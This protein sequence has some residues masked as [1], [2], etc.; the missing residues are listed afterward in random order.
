MKIAITTPTGHIGR[1]IVESLLGKHEL[2]LLCRDASKVADFTKR[3]AKAVTGNL[4]DADYVARA[5]AGADLLFWLTPPK[6]DAPDFRAYQN[7][8]GDN[9]AA[10][11]RKNKLKRVVNLSS[12]G[13]QHASGV[14]PVAGLHSIEKKLNAAIKETGG[15]VCHLR[16]GFF[17]ENF[18]FNLGSIKADGAIYMPVPGELKAIM[19]STGDIARAATQVITDNSWSGVQVRELAGPKDYS[20]HEAARIIGD[21][22]GKPVKHVQVPPEAALQAL[23]QMGASPNLAKDYVEMYAGFAKGLFVAEK[24]R[25][26]KA[27]APTKFE[28]FATQAI[29]PALRG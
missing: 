7:K 24:P 17:Y 6:F 23:T 9:A 27:A 5:T 20:F 8:L 12:I 16:P 11:I 19:I 29:A 14:G 18:F 21:A 4:E 15:S 2:T 13:A 1:G 26:Q 3:G 22:A 28:D 25:D 10:A